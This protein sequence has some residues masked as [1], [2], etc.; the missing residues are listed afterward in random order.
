M[1]Y[2]T[3]VTATRTATFARLQWSYETQ[4]NRSETRKTAVINTDNNTGESRCPNAKCCRALRRARQPIP[5]GDAGAAG[6]S[7]AAPI[8]M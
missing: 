4:V 6:V 2:T 8:V 1:E 7:G 3:T 5:F